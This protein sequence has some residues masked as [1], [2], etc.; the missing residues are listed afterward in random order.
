MR[1]FSFYHV[2]IIL[3]CLFIVAACNRK[4]SQA[5][6]GNTTVKEKKEENVAE[7]KEDKGISVNLEEEGA[8]PLRSQRSPD[9]V[10]SMETTACYG[11]C[12]IYIATLM[13]DG[14]LYYLGRKFVDNVGYYQAKVSYKHI[15]TIDQKMQAMDILSKAQHYPED[16][17]DILDVSNTILTIEF[18]GKRKKIH[19]NHAAPVELNSFVTYLEDFFKNIDWQPASPKD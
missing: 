19:I 5:T 16:G 6:S 1:K 10:V 17:E 15:R 13:S 2:A 4:S 7:R 8:V 3:A 11:E 14:S 9:T 18:K 12:P